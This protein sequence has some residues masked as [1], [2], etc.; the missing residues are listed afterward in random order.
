MK[1]ACCGTIRGPITADVGLLM[2]RLVAGLS[3]AYHGYAKLSQPM[4]GMFFDGVKSLGFPMPEVFGWAAIAAELGG[5]IALALGLLTRPAAFLILCTMAV[6]FF[7]VHA[8]DP[9]Q[10]KELA[11]VY[12]AVALAYLLAGAG[13]ISIDHLLFGKKTT[14]EERGFPV[15]EKY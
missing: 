6:A 2:L 10:V 4:K 15:E 14:T 3:L 1:S 13:R 7:K 5:G 12:G 11:A 9:Y 8:K